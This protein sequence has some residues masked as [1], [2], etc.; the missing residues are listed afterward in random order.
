MRVIFCG[1]ARRSA[2]IT[3]SQMCYRSLLI[4]SFFLGGGGETS[5]NFIFHQHQT[6]L[7]SF[8]LRHIGGCINWG[9]LGAPGALITPA[10]ANVTRAPSEIDRAV[11]R[12][13]RLEE[14]RSQRS[15]RNDGME[16]ITWT[17]VSRR[18]DFAASAPEELQGSVGCSLHPPDQTSESSSKAPRFLFGQF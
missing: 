3:R 16:L 7:P 8:G 6:G 17:D 5:F 4:I 14:G 2:P 11:A 9:L 1:V 15:V 10:D 18:L 13:R 12:K